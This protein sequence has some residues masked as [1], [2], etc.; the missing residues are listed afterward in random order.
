[1]LPNNPSAKALIW[2]FSISL[3]RRLSDTS[4]ISIQ[5]GPS[6]I[7]TELIP[8]ILLRPRANTRREFRQDT[9]IFANVTFEKQWQNAELS[10]SYVRS[11]F[12]GG[13]SA[14]STILDDVNLDLRYD[15]NRQT[16]VQANAGW[17]LREQIVDIEGFNGLDTTQWQASVTM[18]HRLTRQLSLIGQYA[19]RLQQVEGGNNALS[20]GAT[21]TGFLS[22]RYIFDPI[23][24]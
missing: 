22:L 18:T 5:V 21:H 2:D 15:F 17:T 3:S 6:F 20:V 1:M 9:S 11:E 24:F 4:S 23:K 16:F 12:R 14:S 7:S 13:V 8:D 10:L 19:F